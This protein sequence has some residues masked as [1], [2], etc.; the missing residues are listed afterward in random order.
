MKC[1]LHTTCPYL[2][3]TSLIPATQNYHIRAIP[4]SHFKT[5]NLHSMQAPQCGVG[6]LWE[7]IIFDE[8]VNLNIGV[9]KSSLSSSRRG[10]VIRSVGLVGL[11]Y[12]PT[13]S[14][15][16]GTHTLTHS[17]THT[18]THTHNTLTHTHARAYRNTHKCTH[19]HTHTHTQAWWSPSPSPVP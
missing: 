8:S 18:H 6:T 19:T 16:I 15:L 1:I 13:V 9:S 14:G 10:A 3:A 17:H 4:Y 11:C 5:S 12:V 7:D 2:I